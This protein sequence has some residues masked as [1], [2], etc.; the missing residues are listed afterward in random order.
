MFIVTAISTHGLIWIRTLEENFRNFF[1]IFPFDSIFMNSLIWMEI[2]NC[3]VAYDCWFNLSMDFPLVKH[4]I[5]L[6]DQSE[7]IGNL[8]GNLWFCRC[9]CEKERECKLKI[10]LTRSL[11]SLS[12]YIIMD[13]TIISLLCQY[14]NCEWSLCVIFIMANQ[15]I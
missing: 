8:S 1:V 3:Y 7:T 15:F 13:I 5:V 10:I 14:K 4:W 6:I 11:Y 2:V 9:Q 12:V